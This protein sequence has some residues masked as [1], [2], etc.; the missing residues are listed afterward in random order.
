MTHRSPAARPARHRGLGGFRIQGRCVLLPGQIKKGRIVRIDKLLQF[1]CAS[2]SLAA[3]CAVTPAA[4]PPVAPSPPVGGPPAG[5][6]ASASA[7][8]N[9]TCAMGGREI[10]GEPGSQ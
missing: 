4:A 9:A 5:A 1:V 10:H 6:V 7:P 2:L 8:V 3:A